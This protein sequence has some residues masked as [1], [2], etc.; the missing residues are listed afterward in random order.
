MTMKLLERNTHKKF[1][2][3]LRRLRGREGKR[4]SKM[5]M[6]L[7]VVVVLKVVVIII[8]LN[9]S[10]SSSRCIKKKGRINLAMILTLLRF[11]LK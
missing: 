11:D 10:G 3:L 4:R 1:R 2:M 6:V 9:G 8:I 7:I 5:V